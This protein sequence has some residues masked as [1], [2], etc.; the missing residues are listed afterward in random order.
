[1]G[2][3]FG[4]IE[5][6]INR[7]FSMTRNN[8][9]NYWGFQY[10]M[11]FDLSPRH[12]MQV[13]EKANP[14]S[15]ALKCMEFLIEDDSGTRR[16]YGHTYQS[17]SLHI[18]VKGN[19][20]ITVGLV[21]SRDIPLKSETVDR[22]TALEKD[23]SEIYERDRFWESRTQVT[24]S[25]GESYYHCIGRYAHSANPEKIVVVRQCVAMPKTTIEEIQ[26]TYSE[27]LPCGRCYRSFFKCMPEI[28]RAGWLPQSVM[29]CVYS[30]VVRANSGSTFKS[31]PDPYNEQLLEESGDTGR[32]SIPAR[33]AGTRQD[34]ESL[35]T[36]KGEI[37]YAYPNTVSNV[38]FLSKVH[39]KW[40]FPLTTCTR[41]PWHEPSSC[42]RKVYIS[43]PVVSRSKVK[44][45]INHLQK[46]IPDSITESLRA[47]IKWILVRLLMQTNTIPALLRY[48]VQ[49]FGVPAFRN[50]CRR[51]ETAIQLGQ[52]VRIHHESD[53]WHISQALPHAGSR[54][55]M[56]WSLYGGDSDNTGDDTA[57]PGPL[58]LDV[59]NCNVNVLNQVIRGSYLRRDGIKF[60][61]NTDT[62]T[63]SVHLTTSSIMA[64]RSKD[65][66]IH[67]RTRDFGS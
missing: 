59:P 3:S 9:K 60:C 37:I 19:S 32:V 56:V 7:A 36:G 23:A 49:S 16:K 47:E 45:T 46:Q 42:M 39:E 63:P 66:E 38:D 52:T 8:P 33:S 53:R 22:Q 20:E 55:A 61:Y 44:G 48:S 24:F 50:A 6:E 65:E 5:S 34:L 15:A 11:G 58:M 40:H 30:M 14:R 41:L 18:P 54:D 31:I 13:I 17:E 12:L 28:F 21:L 57:S 67:P 43:N 29:V 1:M 2:D 27:D 26:V 64:F 35:S 10:L 51:P 4:R 25:S 62:C